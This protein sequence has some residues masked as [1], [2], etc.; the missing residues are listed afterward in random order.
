MGCDDE[1][2]EGRHEELSSI[3]SESVHHLGCYAYTDVEEDV[4][5]V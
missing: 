1:M 3:R 5:Y 4:F 2:T